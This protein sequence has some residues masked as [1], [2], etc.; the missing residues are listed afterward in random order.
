ME[1]RARRMTSPYER[2]SIWPI[3]SASPRRKGEASIQTP[4]RPDT[5]GVAYNR[6][7]GSYQV[8][9]DRMVKKAVYMNQGDLDRC[10]DAAV[11]ESERP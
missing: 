3:A 7:R 9:R 2:N 10:K 1:S 5:V 8:V 4:W 11:Q 6:G